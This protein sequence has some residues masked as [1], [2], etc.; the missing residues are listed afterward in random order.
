MSRE[1]R[2]LL[3]CWL[4]LLVLG[5]I[6]FGAAFLPFG[7]AYRPLLLLPSLGMVAFI[8]PMFIGIHAGLAIARGVAVTVP[9]WLT[10]LL[11]FGAIDPLTRGLS[12]PFNGLAALARP[13]SLNEPN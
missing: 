10:V 7:H 3:V 12:C 13:C 5:T 9:F 8:A 4:A 2:H 6:E 1:R 11:G